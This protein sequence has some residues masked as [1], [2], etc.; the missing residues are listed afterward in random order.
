MSTGTTSRSAIAPTMPHMEGRIPRVGMRSLAS[1]R[2]VVA[3][4]EELA[5]LLRAL[6]RDGGNVAIVSHG[7]NIARATGLRLAE[8]EIGVVRVEANGTIVAVGQ[9]PG[10]DF[11]PPARVALGTLP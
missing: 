1:G 8:G 4:G 10:S 6:P 9:A 11:G 7:G 2:D 3:A 5:A